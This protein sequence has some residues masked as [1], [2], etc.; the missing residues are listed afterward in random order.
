MHNPLTRLPNR[1]L[2]DTNILLDATFV[3]G[4]ARKA[5]VLLAML[6]FSPAID[7][8]SFQDAERIL[9]DLVGGY[10]FTFFDSLPYLHAFV[11]RASILILPPAGPN[12]GHTVNRADRHLVDAVHQYEAWLLTSDTPL[13][14]ESQKL[15][16]ARLPWDVIMEAETKAGQPPAIEAI[17]RV[18]PVTPES[19][20]IFA[21]IIPGDW[22]GKINVG[23]FTACDVENIGRLYYDSSSQ[24]WVFA[25]STGVAARVEASMQAGETWAACGSYRL[26][27]PVKRGVVSVRAGRYPSSTAIFSQPTLSHFKNFNLGRIEVGASLNQE[28]FLN[29]HV[30]ALV[31]GPQSVSN[32][33]WKAIVAIPE[34][35]PNPYDE[36][37]LQH[38]LRILNGQTHPQIADLIER[39]TDAGPTPIC[40]APIKFRLC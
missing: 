26:P 38:V 20:S 37:S 9:R 16:S 34:G 24:E 36:N 10:I 39:P 29:G 22:A 25:T 21:R 23:E 28:H 11:K 15:I 17:I 27:G 5:V 14:V 4:L 6:G 2:L 30:R 12:T 32:E 33:T 18:V 40:L 35:A 13:I 1:V 31:V 8:I 19:G 7:E 3:N